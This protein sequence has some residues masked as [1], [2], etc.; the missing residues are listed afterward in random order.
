MVGKMVGTSRQERNDAVMNTRAE[1]NPIVTR[2]P[3][4]WCDESGNH[5]WTEGTRRDHLRKRRLAGGVAVAAS[6]WESIDDLVDGGDAEDAH[7]E[8]WQGTREREDVELRSH[9]ELEA[10]VAAVQEAGRLAFGNDQDDVHHDAAGHH[11]DGGRQLRDAELEWSCAISEV[12]ERAGRPSDTNRLVAAT[13]RLG[14]AQD[15]L[16]ALSTTAT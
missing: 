12:V 2:C 11:D 16:N 7:V 6:I 4:E 3:V 9:E 5:E 1:S 10:F 15:A 14:K 8:I 13:I